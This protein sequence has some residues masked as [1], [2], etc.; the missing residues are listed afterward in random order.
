[1]NKLEIVPFYGDSIQALRTPEGKIMV[2]V[3]A[4]CDALGVQVGSQLRR[5][6]Q[7]KWARV[8]QMNTRDAGG[9][10]QELSMI[11]YESVP[12]WL[13][14]I[15]VGKV[16]P[17]ARVKLE[18]YQ[19]E[20]KQVLADHFLTASPANEDFDPT[21]EMSVTLHNMLRQ[22]TAMLA[23]QR[24]QAEQ[25][26]HIREAQRIGQEAAELAIEANEKVDSVAADLYGDTDYVAIVGYC[27][28][29][30]TGIARAIAAKVGK[31]L[32]NYC[33][34]HEIQINSAHN[35]VWG[36]V[37]TYPTKVLDLW[38]D[39]TIK[40]HNVLIQNDRIV[41]LNTQYIHP[42]TKAKYYA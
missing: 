9:S 12:Y 30:G 10:I 11:D 37:H 22:R 4:V 19:L 6:K 40:V 17:E 39:G 31:V 29:K 32:T 27:R 38:W 14:G 34:A 7:V 2:G 1:M 25:E 5:L 42:I 15:K 36:Y 3:R 35:E 24:V 18:Q 16:T 41:D 21:D 8:S 20:V 13:A 33:K 26:I 28:S 23:L